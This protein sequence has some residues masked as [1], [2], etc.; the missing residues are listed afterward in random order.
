M[1]FRVLFATASAVGLLAAA[2][3]T[4]TFS[5][6]VAP[7]LQKNCQGCHRP[8]EAAPFS[9]L[10][11][12]EARPWAASIKEA[13]R[14]KRMPPWPAD[15]HFGKFANDR[16]LSQTD[17]DT[18]VSWASNG[19]PEG[20]PKDLPAPAKFTEGWNIGTP[21]V[22]LTMAEKHHVPAA[23]TIDYQYIL[24]PMN[25]TEDKW[26]QMAEVRPGNRAVLH[27]VIAY[28]REPGSKW[29][30]DAKPGVPWVPTKENGGGGMGNAEFLVGYAPG[31]PPMQHPDGRAKLIKAGSDIVLQIHYTANGKDAYDQSTVGLKY[32]SGP[33]VERA[34]T[35]PAANSRFAIPAG[36]S[37]YEVKSSFEFGTDTKITML[38]PHMHLRGKDFLYKVV[39]PTGE[40]QTLLSV[41][42]YDFNWQLWY[43]P[44]KEIVVPKGTRLE[45]TAHFDNSANNKYNPDPTKV[46]RFGEQSWEEMM[47]GFF[48]VAIDAKANPGSLFPARK[49]A[50]VKPALE[51]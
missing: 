4:P 38:A 41:P 14:M 31:V 46:V 1:I 6:D 10:S 13:V 7:I 24:V 32:A 25:L 2:N 27:H 48:D 3:T 35:L 19:A 37:N 45:C 21:D 43:T 8:G 29:M 40:E 17:I 44:L 26:V 22:L 49:P 15:P 5:H 20:N 28:V 33:V 34:I 18:V 36:D 23:G 39:Y 50:A 47:I 30:K 51:E 42:A 11:Y 9:L 12:K 16:A